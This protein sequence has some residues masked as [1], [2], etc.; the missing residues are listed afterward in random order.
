MLTLLPST[1]AP[2]KGSSVLIPPKTS[3][4]GSTLAVQVVNFT[5][6]TAVEIAC[7]NG[8]I[9]LFEVWLLN[10]TRLLIQPTYDSIANP[11]TA[12]FAFGTS[13]SGVI[14]YL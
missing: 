9:L 1:D 13:C 2:G 4:S 6:Q 7:E 14:V 5:N 11:T 12:T 3:G 10:G 8:R